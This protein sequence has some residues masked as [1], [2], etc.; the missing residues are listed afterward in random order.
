[1]ALTIKNAEAGRLARE[2]A[3]ERGTTVTRAVIG[4]LDEALRRTRG[5]RVAPSMKDA[6][7][8]ISD[9]CAALP[10]LDARPADE[11]LGHG[12]S[13]RPSRERDEVL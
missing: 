7:L 2:L 13:G 4:A 8:E 5:R 10:D 6:I 12:K 1:M 3:R 9:R 11:I